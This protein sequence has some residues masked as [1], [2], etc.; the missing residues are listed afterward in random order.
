MGLLMRKGPKLAIEAARHL[1]NPNTSTYGFA[2]QADRLLLHVCPLMNEGLVE[3]QGDLRFRL[4][5]V[6]QAHGERIHADNHRSSL[7]S[8]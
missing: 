4:T 5:D 8:L 1:V 3:R 2:T 7:F 6:G